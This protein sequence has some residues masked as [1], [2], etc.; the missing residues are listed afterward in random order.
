MSGVS[1][2]FEL[3]DAVAQPKLAFLEPLHLQLIRL[4]GLAKR[5]DRRV[6]IAVFLAQP[7]DLGD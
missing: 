6:E 2:S 3:G 1:W 7:F 5:L 4:S